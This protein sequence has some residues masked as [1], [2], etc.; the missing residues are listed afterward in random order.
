MGRGVLTP[1][2]VKPLKNKN[3]NNNS[4]NNN[5]N[6]NDNSRNN[7]THK[8][9]ARNRARCFLNNISV[10]QTT[11]MQGCCNADVLS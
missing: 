8:H 9:L 3:K 5:C 11:A 6:N 7:K 2:A 10:I 4:K 1:R